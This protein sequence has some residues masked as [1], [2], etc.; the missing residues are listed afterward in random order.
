MCIRDR[1][2]TSV[3]PNHLP[4]R[5][6]NYRDRFE[7]HL[8]IKANDA[9]ISDVRDL[10]LAYTNNT[11]LRGDFFECTHR[12][13]KAALLHRFVAGNASGRFNLVHKKEV[14]GLLP[15]DRA[16]RRDDEDWH[17]LLPQDLLDQLAAPL[18]LSHFFCLVIHHDFVIKKGVNPEAFKARYLAL[19]DACLLYTSP[20]PR[21]ATLSRMPSSA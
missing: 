3:F 7:H 20:S 16:L 14:G 17:N 2:I 19:L 18:C 10:L 13:A 9:V 15:F 8:V 11:N 1:F 4:K 5:I 6:R 12:E 21:D